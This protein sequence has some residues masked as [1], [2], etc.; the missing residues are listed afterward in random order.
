MNYEVLTLRRA[1]KQLAALPLREYD[2]VKAS[3]SALGQ[4]PRPYGCLKLTS[5][6]G[7]RIRVGNYR[8]IYEIDD[9]NQTVT[10]LNVGNRRDVYN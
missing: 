6:P 10:I 9:L 5:R 1:Q 8:V 3:I 7:W 4:S 2:R